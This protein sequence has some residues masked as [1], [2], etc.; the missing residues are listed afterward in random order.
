MPPPGGDENDREQAG[1]GGLPDVDLL[2]PPPDPK[3]EL[4][5]HGG[6]LAQAPERPL[7]RAG[8]VAT[9]WFRV[10]YWQKTPCFGP[11]YDFLSIRKNKKIM[12]FFFSFFFR[13]VSCGDFCVRFF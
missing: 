12:R 13:F 5:R 10:Y 2:L 1:R 3:S 9:R 11:K 7:E 8:K 4:L 6:Q